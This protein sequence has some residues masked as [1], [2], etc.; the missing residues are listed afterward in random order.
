MCSKTSSKFAG[1]PNGKWIEW[2]EN[3]NVATEKSFS[4]GLEVGTWAWYYENG[5][6]R[7]EGSYYIESMIKYPKKLNIIVNPEEIEDKIAVDIFPPV[8]PK[9]GKWTEWSKDG[10]IKV[11]R[12]YNK[13]KFIKEVR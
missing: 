10:K 12:Y 6:K 5:N 1:L 3:G 4:H 7:K 8:R 13:G 9:D 2:F 11:E